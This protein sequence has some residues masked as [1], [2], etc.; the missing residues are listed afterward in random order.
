[1]YLIVGLGNP[2]KDYD[3]TRHNVGFDTVDALVKEYRIAQSGEKF[4]AMYGKGMIPFPHNYN[5]SIFVQGYST[6]YYPI[7]Q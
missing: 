5:T 1:M 3:K 4:K 6:E 2:G 7:F